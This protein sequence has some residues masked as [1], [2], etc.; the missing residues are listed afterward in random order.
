MAGQNS[1]NT[2][3]GAL[4]A[5]RNL[6]AT[7]S[8]LNKVQDRVSTGLRVIGAK[9]NASTFAIAQGIRGD[10]SCNGIHTG[11]G[12]RIGLPAKRGIGCMQ[13]VGGVPGCGG[14]HEGI[15]HDHG[16][17]IRGNPEIHDGHLGTANST[18]VIG[19]GGDGGG[20]RPHC[21]NGAG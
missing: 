5:L 11:D 20:A 1:I 14:K 15:A 6:N 12:G 8:E 9:D 2:N 21:G 10:E 3:V 19:D 17:V 18:A 13:M 4:V 16:G 7:N